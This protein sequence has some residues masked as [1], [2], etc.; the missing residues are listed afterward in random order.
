[1]QIIKNFI[2]SSL[3]FADEA[4]QQ[5]SFVLKKGGGEIKQVLLE[6]QEKA[7]KDHNVEFKSN[8]WVGKYPFIMFDKKKLY[9]Y[10]FIL[11]KPSHSAER[12]KCSK[13]L[14][15]MLETELDVLNINMFITLLDSKKENHQCI[16]TSHTL[17]HQ[18]NN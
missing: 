12:E 1:M 10:F 13:E 14:E 8:L 11:F 7:V 2:R 6:A 16:I 4:L 17:L 15:D 18:M 3:H 5:L 9:G